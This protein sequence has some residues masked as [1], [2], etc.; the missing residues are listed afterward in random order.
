MPILQETLV[1]GTSRCFFLWEEELESYQPSCANFYQFT[2]R[3]GMTLGC[4]P[5][6]TTKETPRTEQLMH[7]GE[8]KY[9]NNFGEII[10][11]CVFIPENSRNLYVK[12]S[13]YWFLSATAFKISA[14][15]LAF[16]WNAALLKKNPSA[17]AWVLQRLLFLQEMLICSG[18][19]PPQAAVGIHSIQHL[20]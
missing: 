2:G 18:V 12:Y 5:P 9:V 3:S 6:G 7:S 10:I 17:F 11:L 14:P 19:V 4:W 15:A 13:T 20:F 16:P 8:G 1:Y